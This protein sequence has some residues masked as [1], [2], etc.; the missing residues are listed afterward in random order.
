MGIKNVLIPVTI[1]VQRHDTYMYTLY[2]NTTVFP[3]TVGLLLL[4]FFFRTL[5]IFTCI[6]CT[7]NV[8]E[9]VH[10]SGMQT[11]FVLC[12]LTHSFPGSQLFEVKQESPELCINVKTKLK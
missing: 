6:P 12:K 8:V 2:N 7:C 11:G 5:R 10:I 4:D 9:Y 3:Y 1:C